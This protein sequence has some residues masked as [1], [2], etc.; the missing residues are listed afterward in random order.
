MK[1]KTFTVQ[2]RPYITVSMSI[3]RS[4][5]RI[6]VMFDRRGTNTNECF[7]IP[8]T[9]I[10]Q[11]NVNKLEFICIEDKKLNKNYEYLVFTAGYNRVDSIVI[12]DVINKKYS[13]SNIEGLHSIDNITINI[14]D[15]DPLIIGTCVMYHDIRGIESDLF[16]DEEIDSYIQTFDTHNMV[17]FPDHPKIDVVYYNGRGY[18]I[19]PPKMLTDFENPTLK[20]EDLKDNKNRKEAKTMPTKKTTAVEA[21]VESKKEDPTPREIISQYAEAYDNMTKDAIRGNE[22]F[23]LLSPEHRLSI[24]A[25][26]DQIVEILEGY[27]K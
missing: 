1:T 9:G 25:H 4:E 17:K 6:N 14:M 5:K 19:L 15:V 3:G 11:F 21:N 2:G 20:E 26:L 8:I 7:T 22:V 27:I 13:I 24:A 12:I 18:R 23:G 10:N 16:F